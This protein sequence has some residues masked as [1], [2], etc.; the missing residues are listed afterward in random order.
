MMVESLI[1]YLTN[2]DDPIV[3]SL[4]ERINF[5]FFPMVNPDGVFEGDATKA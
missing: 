2:T 1:K 3:C 5:L 4:L